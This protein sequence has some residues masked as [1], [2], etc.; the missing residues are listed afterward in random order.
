MIWA[1]LEISIKCPH[2]DS[3][4]HVD[5][6]YTEILCGSC[7]SP[8]E[9]PPEIW[10]DMLE[11][12]SS[13]VPAMKPKEGS[14]STIFGHFN[15]SLMYGRRDP[16]CKKCKRDF[17]IEKEYQGQDT[18]VCPDCGE[19]TPI[20]PAPD[21]LKEAIHGSTLVLGAWPM[22]DSVEEK[23]LSGPVAFACP[24]CAGSLMIDGTDRLVKCGYCETNVYLPDDLWLRLHPAKKKGRWYIGLD[25]AKVDPPEDGEAIVED[26]EDGEEEDK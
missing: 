21:W 3:P 9:F 22:S 7:Q 5:G 11:D 14:N 4:V 10:K 2:C 17:D 18:L 25:G 23:G 8:I 20:F 16:F 26:D 12:V 13:E 19:K 6:P 15:M 1:A 24:K